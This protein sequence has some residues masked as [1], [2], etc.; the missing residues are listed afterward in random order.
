[1]ALDRRQLLR[2][3][4]SGAAALTAGGRAAH[5]QETP[6]TPNLSE[7]EKRILADIES[8]FKEQ[9][10]W[11]IPA[12]TTIELHPTR[13]AG[14][15]H[16]RLGSVK[17]AVY[18]DGVSQG[19]IDLVRPVHNDNFHTLAPGMFQALH[20]SGKFPHEQREKPIPTM[21]FLPR[22]IKDTLTK[23]GI[24]FEGRT[25]KLSRDR[26]AWVFDEDVKLVTFIQP[27]PDQTS[28]VVAN[29]SYTGGGLTTLEFKLRSSGEM[30][31]RCS[32][33]RD[34]TPR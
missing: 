16:Q 27:D 18:I 19:E 21:R 32:L 29:I 34:V 7:T 1:M 22:E 5:A 8:R 25:I 15:D 26:L 14:Q 31:F 3:A 33:M 2:T 11:L 13:Y 4:A 20:K 9:Y 10:R 17:I 12:K 28:H 30:A 6:P 23:L 24:T